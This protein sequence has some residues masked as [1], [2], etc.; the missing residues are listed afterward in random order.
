M[1]WNLI[2]TISSATIALIITIIAIIYIIRSKRNLYRDVLNKELFRNKIIHDNDFEFSNRIYKN[3]DYLNQ[4]WNVTSERNRFYGGEISGRLNTN[5][6]EKSIYE[7]KK[8]KY[9][10]IANIS[11][12]YADKERIRTFYNDYFKEPTLKDLI[13]ETI[14]ETNAD[15]KGSIPT[16][17]ESKI[18]SKDLS[19]WISTIKLPDLT[20]TGMF[21]RYQ[22]ETIK[23]DQVKL[24]LEEDDIELSVLSDFET[25]VSSIT[26]EFG[27]SFE[28]ESL[29]I[30]RTVLK[31]KAAERTLANLEKASGW[32]LI[33][34]NFHI[35]KDKNDFYKVTMKHPV[36]NY[37]ASGKEIGISCLIP[38][39][40]IE[41]SVAGNYSNSID[42]LIPLTIYGQVWQPVN[43]QLNVL[44]LIITP[45]AI[46]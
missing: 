30:H 46:Y 20:E 6:E 26:N 31:E 14:S 9:L 33:E 44:E 16:I 38:V 43:R 39:N 27:Y 11:F 10:N 8:D 35:Q 15:V 3:S 45:L 41:S 19:K 1:N 24:G 34:G 29:N 32:V 18:G 23:K 21:K 17:I 4:K 25:K 13:K 28:K 42:K 40:Q 36:S 7:K 37:L 2:I 12:H 22:I 5:N